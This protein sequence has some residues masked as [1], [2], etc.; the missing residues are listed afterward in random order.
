[1]PLLASLVAQASVDLNDHAPGYEFTTWSA[2]QLS[3][4]ALEG[5]QV[6]FTMRPDLFLRTETVKLEPGTVVQKP[7]GCTQIRRVYGVSNAQG[8]VLYPIRKIKQSD[9]MTWTG[10]KCPVDPRHYRVR[11]YAID[12]DNDTLIV[13]PAPPAG[14]DVFLLVECAKIP[15]AAEFGDS[16]EI[17]EELAAPV[18][19]WILFRAKMVDSENNSTIFQVATRHEQSFYTLLQVQMRYHDRIDASHAD[20]PARPEAGANA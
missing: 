14:Q 13:S 6:A 18:I 19:Q 5:L 8:R 1:M 3:A 10:R 15:T 12:T 20:A 11:E 16:T 2:A 9:R 4:Y 7:C 17:S